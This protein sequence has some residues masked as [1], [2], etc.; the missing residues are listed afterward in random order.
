MIAQLKSKS[1]R[2]NTPV[3]T[4]HLTSWSLA[5]WFKA[6]QGFGDNSSF[7]KWLGLGI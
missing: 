5:N 2:D 1:N 4:S 3:I 6:G 7:N